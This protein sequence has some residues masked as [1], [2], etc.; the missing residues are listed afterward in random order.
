VPPR[1]LTPETV[2]TA[3]TAL[4]DRQ[5]IEALTMRALARALG[6][7]AMSLYH[8]F[9]GKDALLDAM[10]DAVYA[11]IH[12]PDTTGPWRE[13]LRRRSISVRAVLT[14][15]PWALPLMESRRTPGPANLSY[16]DANIAC[17][18]AAGFPP[19]R[20]AQA[21]AVIDA[22]VY[23]FVLQEATLPF[24]SGEEAA[25]MIVADAFGDALQTYPNMAW[26]AQ[27]VI[28]APGYSF[29][30]EFEPGLDL[31]LDGVEDRLTRPR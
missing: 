21:Y 27:N 20:V 17:L 4:A 8:H 10:V 31:V 12:L 22:F 19:E 7:E 18:R 5:G 26:F 23:G 6:V 29:T 2:V 13:E 14:A 16:H 28:L 25:T 30:R 3:A 11:E 1:K 24:D 15:H 9:A